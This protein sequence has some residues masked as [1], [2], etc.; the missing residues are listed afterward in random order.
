[1]FV[2]HPLFLDVSMYDT[3]SSQWR[4]CYKCHRVTPNEIMCCPHKLDHFRIARRFL[5]WFLAL[6]AKL[7]VKELVG[8]AWHP[9]PW[10]LMTTN[11]TLAVGIVAPFFKQPKTLS[12]SEHFVCGVFFFLPTQSNCFFCSKTLTQPVFGG[13]DK[14][15]LHMD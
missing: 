3:N 15:L 10:R 5:S 8:F 2:T 12:Q 13:A 11:H 14:P 6:A 4:L 9:V 1:M 7:G